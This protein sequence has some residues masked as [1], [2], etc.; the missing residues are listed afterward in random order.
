MWYFSVQ[1]T[2]RKSCMGFCKWERVKHG[3]HPTGYSLGFSFKSLPILRPRGHSR[4]PKWQDSLT[5]LFA[6]IF[7]F[8]WWSEVYVNLSI[9]IYFQDLNETLSKIWGAL[10]HGLGF[11]EAKIV[12]IDLS[13]TLNSIIFWWELVCN[14]KTCD[15]PCVILTHLRQAPILHVH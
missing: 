6:T 2:C 7:L 15:M 14:Y 9:K 1:D 5:C 10:S 4:L 13:H 3:G 11:N 12:K 8:I